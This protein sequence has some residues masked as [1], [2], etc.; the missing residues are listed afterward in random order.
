MLLLG[1]LMPHPPLLVPDVGKEQIAKVRATAE[2]MQKLAAEIK[3]LQPETIIIFSPHGPVFSD[4]MAIR[5]GSW[6]RG[7]LRRFGSAR[8]FVRRV[9][10]EGSRRW[11]E[12]VRRHL[13]HG[14]GRS[15]Q[16]HG[17]DPC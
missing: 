6:S 11:P 8:E 4:G 9:D 7:H 3:G 15:V 12:A 1:A 10:G 5:G 2:A 14:D 13:H 16:R 17:I